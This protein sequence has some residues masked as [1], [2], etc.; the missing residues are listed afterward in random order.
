MTDQENTGVLSHRFECDR[1]MVIIP[2]SLSALLA[3]GEMIAR[4]Y[5]PGELFREVH[6]VSTSDDRPDLTA[7]QKAVGSARLVF[8]NLPVGRRYFIRTC[9]WQA[10]LIEPFLRRGVDLARRI[11]PSLVRTHNNFLEGVLA[12]RIKE[13]CGIPFVVSLHGVWDVDDR[14]TRLAR[15]KATFR[16]KLERISLTSA[17]SVIA[18][19]EPIIRYAKSRGARQVELIYNVVAGSEIACKTDYRLHTPPRLLTVNRQVDDKNPENVI[20]AIAELDCRYTLVG[21]G[22]LHEPLKKLARDLGCADRVEFIKA[23]PNADLCASLKDFDAFVSHCDYWGMSKTIVEAALAGLPII[24][25]R[26]PEIVVGEY[27]GGWILECENSA[28]GYRSAISSLLQSMERRREQGQAAYE[29]A[30][31]R[32]DPE[33]MERRLTGLYLGLT[34]A[35]GLGSSASEASPR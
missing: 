13:K 1:L 23:M 29:A 27:A 30:R 34:K 8:H 4:Y 33:A 9:G 21:D 20:R 17:D 15:V 7:L 12:S 16:R 18:V 25:N 6:I 26:H 11:R 28:L 3:K 2:D 10:P 24:I 31:R 35:G 5:N 19:Y 14:R 22:P 32:F